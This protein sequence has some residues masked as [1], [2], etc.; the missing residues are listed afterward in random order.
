MRA[1]VRGIEAARDSA[2]IR[3]RMSFPTILNG[4]G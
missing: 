2:E 3:L 4:T 1:K